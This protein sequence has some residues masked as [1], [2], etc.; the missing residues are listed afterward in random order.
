MTLESCSAQRKEGLQKGRERDRQVFGEGGQQGAKGTGE[1]SGREG[2]L[3]GSG[4]GA[5]T[6]VLSLA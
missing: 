1:P 6:A 4:D 3:E 2:S 5:R